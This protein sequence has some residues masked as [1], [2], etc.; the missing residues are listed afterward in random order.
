ML[1]HRGLG[2]KSVPLRQRAEAMPC[3]QR[4]LALARFRWP[5]LHEQ[6]WIRLGKTLDERVVQGD[7]GAIAR[8]DMAKQ[9]SLA[10]LPGPGQ[11]HDRE[12][13]R[14]ADHHGFEGVGDLLPVV[15]GVD[16]QK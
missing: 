11:Q 13:P 9:G 10:D 3:G 6:R 1:S 12:L 7:V 4:R 2:V 5:I 15:L 8:T 16:R 14:G